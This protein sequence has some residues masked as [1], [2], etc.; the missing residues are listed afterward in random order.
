MSAVT[1]IRNISSSDKH[2]ASY[3][4]LRVEMRVGMCV[5]P[6]VPTIAVQF[7]K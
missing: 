4:R 1:A 5:G 3:E 2:L 6:L 7:Q